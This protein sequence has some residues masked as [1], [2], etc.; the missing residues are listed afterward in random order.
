MGNTLRSFLIFPN[1]PSMVLPTIF[2]SIQVSEE[3]KVEPPPPPEEEIDSPWRACAW[4][5]LDKLQEF[6]KEDPS[7]ARRTNEEGYYP[8]QGAALNNRADVIEYLLDKC[9]GVSIDAADHTGQTA[10][11]FYRTACTIQ[12]YTVNCLT[13]SKTVRSSW[14][15]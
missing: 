14:V 7:C 13:V 15:H 1:P 10:L 5:R 8:L 6:L 3:V 12:R 9:T 2:S 4:G 11:H